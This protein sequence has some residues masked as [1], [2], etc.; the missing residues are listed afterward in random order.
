MSS[1]AGGLMSIRDQ[2]NSPIKQLEKRLRLGAAARG[3]AILTSVALVATVLLVLITNAFAFSRWSISTARGVLL[4]ALALAVSFGIAIPL[5][6]LTR[7]R[8]ARSAEAIFPEFQQ[9]LVTF[10]ERDTH[11]R[12][13]FI[14]LLAADTLNVARAAEPSRLVPDRTL[15]TFLGVGAASLCVLVWMILAGP[16]YLGHGAALLWAATPRSGSAPFYDI[17]V[18]PGDVSVRRN[19][20]QIVTAQVIGLQ[21]EAVRLYARYESTSKWDQVTMRPQAGASGFQF[22]FAG[23]PESVEY[24]V[25]AGPLRSRHFNIRVLDL[26]GVKNVRVTY[27][28]PEWTRMQKV[29]EER[30]GDLRAVEGTD[31]SLEIE[32]DRPMRDGVLVVNDEQQIRL[33]GGEGNIYKGTVRMEKDGLY[34]V[35]AL[36]QGQPVR[37]SNDFF[38]EA[39]KADPPNVVI[40]R[41]R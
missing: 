34:H 16:G 27:H 30:G 11:V 5:R 14:E 37:L 13:P 7:R 10:A 39:R 32:T 20:D 9:R 35:A 38:I 36:D 12:D 2:L 3:A 17:Q 24:Y 41:P 6:A 1:A 23:L 21:T 18:T 29:V 8:T 22:V 28:Y 33:S 26:P 19:A 15:A 4:F 25:E 31:A 40:A